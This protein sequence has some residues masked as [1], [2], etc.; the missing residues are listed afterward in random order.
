MPPADRTPSAGRERLGHQHV[1]VHRH[2]APADRPERAA[3]TPFVAS[4]RAGR[5]HPAGRRGQHHAVGVGLDARRRHVCSWIRTPSSS[6]ARAKPPRQLGRI[7]QALWSCSQRPARYVGNRPRR[8][9]R[10]IE[11]P[12]PLAERGTA[13]APSAEPSTCV[14]L[15]GHG[16]ARR[17]APVALDRRTARSA[18]RSP[19]RF[20]VAEPLNAVDL[21][22]EALDP[23]AQTVRQ[24]AVE[25]TLRCGR[26]RRTRRCPVPAPRR[27]GWVALLGLDGRPQA[28]EP[29][30]DDHQI[31]VRSPASG[32]AGRRVPAIQPER[33]R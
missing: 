14:G 27:R 1:V 12:R 26:W 15:D 24:R 32:A 5:A 19:S 3:G 18:S 6:A 10:P 33:D 25:E 13:R 11:I 22:G 29:A 2:H 23:V 17:S 31:R 4:T 20:S 8:G 28:G 9:P 7:D 30:A 16:H 21:V